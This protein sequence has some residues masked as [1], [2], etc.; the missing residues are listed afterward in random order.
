[1]RLHSLVLLAL[2]AAAPAAASALLRADTTVDGD[3]VTLGDVFEDAGAAAE[4]RLAAAPPPGERVALSASGVRAIAR[5]NGIE[6]GGSLG[7]KRVWVARSGS[8]VSK[9][10]IVAA[11]EDALYESGLDGMVRVELASRRFQLHVPIDMMPSVAVEEVD[12]DS[13]TRRFKATLVAP[14]EGTGGARA[15]VS[16]SAHRY[17]EVPVLAHA[18]AVGDIIEEDDIDWIELRADRV[19]RNIVTDSAEI[20]GLAPRRRIRAGDAIRSRDV[21]RPVVVAKGELVTLIMQTESMM[22]TVSGRAT[23]DGSQDEVIDVINTESRRVVQ[24][25]VEG[26]T[27]I[28]VV[29]RERLV[30]AAN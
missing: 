28:R 16:G 3:T 13:R 30:A 2:L 6:W 17:V 25:I 7:T 14:A 24:G 20:I 15:E 29:P 11:I 1:M 27:R 22:L 5:A 8:A 4:V 12:Y 9:A 19:R 10:D 18:V 26:P 21:Q 23:E